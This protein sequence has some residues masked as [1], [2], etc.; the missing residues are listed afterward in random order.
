MAVFVCLCGLPGVGKSTVARVLAAQT[1]AL[2]LRLDLIEAAIA[3][4]DF[5]PQDL[6]D[7]GYRAL[8]AAAEGAL[9]QGID[10]IG[11]CVNP[12]EM[13][14]RLFQDASARVKAHHLDV[15]LVCSDQ[16]E[17]R[18]RVEGRAADIPGLALPSWAAV[19]AREWEPLAT[20]HLSID[21]IRLS[22]ED[23]AKIIAVHMERP[24]P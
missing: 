13:T 20:G 15:E 18:K 23:A 16:S 17:H 14:R 1:G 5:A 22:A 6:A 10:V 7:L 4:S 3:Q 8:A 24:G 9:S 12:I 19:A 11:D 2:W 21:T